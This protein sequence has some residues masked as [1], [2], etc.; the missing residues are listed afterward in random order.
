[1]RYYFAMQSSL[2]MREPF[3]ESWLLDRVLAITGGLVITGGI[4]G[5]FTAVATVLAE[6]VIL[7]GPASLLQPFLELAIVAASVGGIAGSILGPI[8]AWGFMRRV[9]L[10]KAI[11]GTSLGTIVGGAV[12]TV[13]LPIGM[14]AGPVI[15]FFAAAIVLFCKHRSSSAG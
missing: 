14:L 10:W 6:V 3:A 8:G 12:G 15:G 7:D 1:M 13:L 5:A 4:A 9:P 11:L 2:E